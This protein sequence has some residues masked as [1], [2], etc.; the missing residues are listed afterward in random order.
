MAMAMPCV[1]CKSNWLGKCRCAMALPSHCARLPALM[2]GL[3]KPAASLALPPYC[4]MP[5]RLPSSTNRLHACPRACRTSLGCS[6]SANCRRCWKPSTCCPHRRI[7]RLWMATASHT[8]AAWALPH[9]LVWS[10]AC[11]VLAWA[12]A[13]MWAK[14]GRHCT[15][16][17]VHSRH[18][19]MAANK[20]AGC[21]AAN[22]AAC[23]W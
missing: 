11:P 2:S 9:I 22:P 14:R 3:R 17:G 23:R 5:A 18:C 15:G 12:K 13:F 4:W 7:W 6:V 1:R 16:C 19:A 21:C 20:L 10:R 8:L